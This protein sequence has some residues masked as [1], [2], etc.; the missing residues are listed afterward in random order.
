[1]GSRLFVLV[2]DDDLA[3][4]AAVALSFQ[5]DP[6]GVLVADT[7]GAAEQMLESW[8]VR[9]AI[10][11]LA[12]DQG[13]ALRFASQAL[14]QDRL[15]AVV[16]YTRVADGVQLARASVAGSVVMKG[17]HP[18]ELRAVV[19]EAAAQLAEAKRLRRAI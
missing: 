16:F 14:E 1:V 15:D 4:A 3:T 2:L 6:L 13:D 11:E 12:V 9:L 17:C 19:F 8:H 5:N 7:V 10:V 18:S